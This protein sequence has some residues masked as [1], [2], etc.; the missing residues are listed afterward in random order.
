MM[1]MECDAVLF[2]NNKI[3]LYSQKGQSVVFPLNKIILNKEG[4]NST[5]E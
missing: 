1:H 4:I 2:E 5:S 3:N